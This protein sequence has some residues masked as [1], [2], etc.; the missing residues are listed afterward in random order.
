[1][2]LLPSRGGLGATWPVVPRPEGRGLP[3][4]RAGLGTWYGPTCGWL[5]PGQDSGL[6][7]ALPV[8]GWT[9]GRTRDLVWLYLWLAGPRAGLGTWYGPT[10]GWLD[11]GED[12]GL[13]MAL[14]VAGQTQGRTRDLVWPYLWLAGWPDPGQDSG[15]GMALPVAGWLAGPRAGLGTWYGPTCGWHFLKTCVFTV[16]LPTTETCGRLMLMD[17]SLRRRQLG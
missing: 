5:D 6:G 17:A 2:G 1:M 12:S 7:M 16:W 8:A 13:G 9:Q 11:P 10:C 14:P 15:L 3:G 4:P